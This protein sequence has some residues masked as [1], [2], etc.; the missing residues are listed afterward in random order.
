MKINKLPNPK[1]A[2]FAAAAAVV[3]GVLP[4]EKP[5]VP[6]DGAV[7]PMP[8]AENPVVEEGVATGV[9]PPKEN[10]VLV[11]GAAGVRVEPPRLNPVLVPVAVPVAVPTAGVVPKLK[12]LVLLVTVGAIA[13]K[14]KK[15]V[16][17]IKNK[18]FQMKSHYSW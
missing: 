12:P 7:P 8:V 10:P 3:C 18:I 6:R 5:P 15:I 2:G 11:V 16:T 14:K 17:V 4:N 9:P 1:P 13:E